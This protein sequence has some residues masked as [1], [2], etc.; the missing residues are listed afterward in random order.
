MIEQ[1]DKIATLNDLLIGFYLSVPKDQYDKKK[2]FAEFLD[3][4]H[5]KDTV[6]Q[7][8]KQF[9]ISDVYNEREEWFDKKFNPVLEK[10]VIKA[11][12]YEDIIS[13]LKGYKFHVEINK[14][15]ELCLQFNK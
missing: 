1:V 12:L 5:I 9:K 4:E 6:R 14:F 7:R 13:D 8:I 3:K 2:N 11:I 15:Y 10:I